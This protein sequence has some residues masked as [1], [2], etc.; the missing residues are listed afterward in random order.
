METPSKV[1]RKNRVPAA[2]RRRPRDPGAAA[3]RR[4]PSAPLLAL[5]FALALALVPAIPGAVRALRLSVFFPPARA[6]TALGMPSSCTAFVGGFLVFCAVFALRRIPPVAYVAVHE[7]T[8]ALFGLLFGARVSRLRVDSESGSVDVTRRNAVILLAPYF[9]PPPLFAVLAVFGLASLFVPLAGTAAGDAF[10]AVAGA[11]WGF[12]FCFTVNALL[13]YQTDLDAYGFFFSSVLLAL[14][15]L[16]VLWLCFVAL[17]PVRAA[18][19]WA[20]ASSSLAEAYL[21]VLDLLCG[22]G[23]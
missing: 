4:P 8:H 2:P 9:F 13:Q 21:W 18:A 15:N 12:H 22:R 3:L 5:L 19:A 14:L 11:A 17:S 20:D 6:R 7:A 16:A 1:N 10:S 23:G